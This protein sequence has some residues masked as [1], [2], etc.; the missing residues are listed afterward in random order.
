MAVIRVSGPAAAA[1]LEAVSGGE[2]PKPR[3]ASLRKFSGSD[4]ALIDEGLVLW[5]PEPGSF[6]GE[7][8]AEF[9]VH[10]GRAVVDALLAALDALPGLRPAEAGEFTRRAVENG[11]FDLTQ[12][13]ALADLIN[14]ETEAQRRQAVVQ[15]GGALAALYDDWRSRL[16]RAAAWAE[17]AIDFSDEEI[18][19]DAIAT[20]KDQVAEIVGEIQAHLNDD[21]R[22]EILRDG[23]YLTVI[24]PPNSGKSSL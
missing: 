8:V 13:E 23:F 22:G 4:G 14:A 18:P 15:Y 2:T 19:P 24:G 3:L 21:R 20:A 6:T 7:D 5:F 17:A 11:K 10:G 9:H 1:A 12:A 16:I